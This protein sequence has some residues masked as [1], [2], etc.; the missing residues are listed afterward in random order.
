VA[1]ARA[2]QTGYAAAQSAAP[3][4]AAPRQI[5][6][7]VRP[8][9]PSPRDRDC[10]AAAVYYEA[11]GESAAGQ[12]AVA[13]VVLNRMSRPTYPKSVCGV[14]YQGLASGECQ[15]SF[16]CNGAM[17]GRREPLAW[18]KAREVATRALAG[19]VMAAIGKA[20]CFHATHMAQVA[21]ADGG[22]RLGG[23]VFY[24]ALSHGIFARVRAASPVVRSDAASYVVAQGVAASVKETRA[25][26]PDA[27]PSA[28][29]APAA[30]SA[31]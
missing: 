18:V 19:Y 11:R 21:R 26:I 9:A 27:Q 4:P 20:T 30:K 25:A 12:A 7:A 3:A 10:L 1:F 8:S 13:Q 5:V 16:A 22:V 14:V 29:A 15:F 24:T 2:A 6:A 23:H 17:H 31:S 28:T